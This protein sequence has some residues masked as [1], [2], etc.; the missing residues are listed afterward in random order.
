M[1]VRFRLAARLRLR[2]WSRLIEPLALRKASGFGAMTVMF[3]DDRHR[4]RVV[5]HLDRNL[6]ATRQ[7]DDRLVGCRTAGMPEVLWVP[8]A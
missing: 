6:A 8:S 5:V 4:A 2:F 3:D 7:R 1:P